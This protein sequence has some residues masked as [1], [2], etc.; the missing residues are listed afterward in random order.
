MIKKL[1]APLLLLAVA[2]VFTF[3]SRTGLLPPQA[4]LLK[5]MQQ[6]VGS[7]A[8]AWL[9]VIAALETTVAINVYF[10]GALVILAS[11]AG[12]G[13]R[14]D[15]VVRTFLFII[16]GQ[17]LGVLAS[18]FLG[19]VAQEKLSAA[20][21]QSAARTGS[22]TAFNFL[23][24]AHPHSAALTSFRLGYQTYPLRN[25][26]LVAG[27]SIVVWGL[28]WTW[29][30]LRGMWLLRES[31]WDAVFLAYVLSWILWIAVRHWR[32]RRV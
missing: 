16:I 11:M 15:L 4:T 17:A 30:S 9:I 21:E 19:R 6:L 3:A 27:V 7:S 31:P 22:G 8:A 29:V 14:L 12:T 5:S 26:V 32:S 28:F 10:P 13:G 24:Y 18:Y 1:L 25:F 2:I 23:T 20:A